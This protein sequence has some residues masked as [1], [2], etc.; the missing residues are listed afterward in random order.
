MVG[1]ILLGLVGGLTYTLIILNPG[2]RFSKLGINVKDF[3]IAVCTNGLLGGVAGFVGW[4]LSAGEV[5]PPR[6]YSVYL[7]FGVGGGSLIQSLSLAIARKDLTATLDSTLQ[8]VE[9]LSAAQTKPAAEELRNLSRSLR[10]STDSR[11]QSRLAKDLL[12]V[13]SK[14]KAGSQG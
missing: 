13:A 1:A 9:D 2:F 11:E 7:L 6:S 3:F 4:S 5:L 10:D 8:A 12:E 14:A